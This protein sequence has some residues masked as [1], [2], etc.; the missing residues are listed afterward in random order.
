M[1]LKKPEKPWDILITQ[2]FVAKIT[3]FKFIKPN[4]ITFFRVIFASSS[5]FMLSQAEFICGSFLFAIANLMD[6]LDGELARF[7]QTKSE[8]GHWFDL[9]TD[10]FTI[11]G[12]FIALGIGFSKSLGILPIISGLISGIA[13]LLIFFIRNKIEQAHGKIGVKQKSFYGFESED[14]LY[15]VPLLAIT[16]TLIYFLY[17]SA[18]GSPIG[19]IITYLI[20]KKL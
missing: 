13:I 15:I 19:V 5:M 18:I 3:R 7:T 11:V 9:V 17:L 14:I 20:Y 1:D 12:F 16:D 8:F 10:G 6:H 2:F 4:H